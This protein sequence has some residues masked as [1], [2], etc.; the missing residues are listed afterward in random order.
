MREQRALRAT[1]QALRNQTV[2]QQRLLREAQLF[3]TLLDNSHDA[4]H[5]IEP[6]TLRIL[7][8]NQQGCLELGYSREKLLRMT[9]FDFAPELNASGVSRVLAQLKETG[10]AIFES[11]HRRQD[12]TTFPVEINLRQV[13]LDHTYHVAVSRNISDRKQSE[14]ALRQSEADLHR[15]QS[16]AHIGS[17]RFDLLQR[18]GSFSA[19]TYRIL[20]LS[21]T[22]LLTYQDAMEKV[23]AEDFT[24]V[25]MEWAKSLSSGTFDLEHRIVLSGHVS[26]EVRWVR[27][28]AQL[29]YDADHRPL[30]A[31]G[32]LQGHFRKQALRGKIARVRAGGR[33][34]RRHDCGGR[35]RLSLHP[36]KSGVPSLLEKDLRPGHR[37][38]RRRNG[39]WGLI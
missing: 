22:S 29:E 10:S 37:S 11:V 21:P 27:T 38:F 8:I 33:K 39:P 13:H 18:T 32:T 34:R 2:E 30:L 14:E 35:P 12:G 17:W 25:S 1:N 5:I 3:R 4:V 20:G 36:G 19:E 23:Y 15:A 24:K 6:H 28:R 7:D 31:V 26:P 16:I 9:V